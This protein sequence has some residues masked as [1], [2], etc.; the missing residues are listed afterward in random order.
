MSVLDALEQELRALPPA[1]QES[2]LAEAARLA[3]EE[4][5]TRPGTRDLAALLKEY[6]AILGEL[7]ERSREAPSESDP[8]QQSQERGPAPIPI[9]SRRNTS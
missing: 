4:L 5:D 9:G 8:I 1:L 6:R 7:R 2:S 3:A